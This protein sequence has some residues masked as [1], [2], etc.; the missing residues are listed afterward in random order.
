M[1]KVE[2]GFVVN[3]YVYHQVFKIDF[4]KKDQKAITET[5]FSVVLWDM[6]WMNQE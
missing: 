2:N 3:V 5:P 6:N 1:C 4:N